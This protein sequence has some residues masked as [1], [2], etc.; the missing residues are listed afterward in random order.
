MRHTRIADLG[1]T[2]RLTLRQVEASAEPGLQL[3]PY[4]DVKA[5]DYLPSLTCDD[6]ARFAINISLKKL[7]PTSVRDLGLHS[8][9]R[10]VQ[11]HSKLPSNFNPDALG[12]L[13][14]LQACAAMGHISHASSSVNYRSMNQ[15]GLVLLPMALRGTTTASMCALYGGGS[16][17]PGH[18]CNP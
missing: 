11:G 14:G 15:R 4:Q 7:V 3:R 16:T 12:V 18:V 2:L 9:V 10:A 6:E 13:L 1:E 17:P 8:K 5:A